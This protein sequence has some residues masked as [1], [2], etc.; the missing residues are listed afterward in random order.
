MKRRE[1][2]TL[3]GAVTAAWPLKVRAQQPT[4]PVIGFLSSG[5]SNAYVRYAVG[6]RQG[7]EESGYVEGQN[8][9]LGE[10]PV[11]CAPRPG[12]RSGAPSGGRDRS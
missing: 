3:L 8:I 11:R 5:S 4:I 6:F 12:G 2:I 1:F 7:L 10:W 9:S